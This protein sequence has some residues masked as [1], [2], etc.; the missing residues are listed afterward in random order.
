MNFQQVLAKYRSEA[1]SEADKGRRFERLMANFL[2]TYQVYDEAFRN[3]WLWR[4]FPWRSDISPTDIGIDLVAETVGGEYWAVQCKCYA[5]DAVITKSHV[6]TFLNPSGRGFNYQDGKPTN[7]SHRLWISTTNRWNPQAENSLSGQAIPCSR[8]G[9]SDLEL[10]AVD[11]DLL[12]QGRSGE[13]ARLP[14]KELRDHQREALEKCSS[15][16]K[17]ADRCKLISACGSGKTFTALRIA[18]VL[19]GGRGLVVFLA[20]SIA[21]IGQTLREWSEQASKPIHAVCVCSDPQVSR[22]GKEQDQDST[23]TEDLALPASTNPKKIAEELER[24]GKIHPDRLHV[25][26]STYQSIDRVAEALKSL[27]RPADLI[28][29]DE[30]HRTTGATLPGAKDESDFGEDL[31]YFFIYAK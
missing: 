1:A 27:G 24:A 30:A 2:R 3:V 7:F 10:A 6:D 11:W 12:D 8:L 13:A 4:D 17:D 25:I 26:L 14:R 28:I 18:E 23:R 31:D 19:T 15:A 5:A 22:G 9:L 29:C 20:P 16:L 21:L